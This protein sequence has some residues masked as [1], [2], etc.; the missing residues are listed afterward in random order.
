[1]NRSGDT[2]GP[3]E[4]GHRPLPALAAPALERAAAFFRAA[5]EV[6]RLR[7]LAILLEGEWCVSDLAEASGDG[8]STVSQRLKVLR[9]ERLVRRRR[10]G[11][12]VLYSL[13]DEHVAALIR[14]ALDHA[15]HDPQAHDHERAHEPKEIR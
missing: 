6:E 3:G 10:D 5:G 8:L 11:K 7:L 9:S 2:C 15:A 13:A 14:S 4:H 1:M 12:H